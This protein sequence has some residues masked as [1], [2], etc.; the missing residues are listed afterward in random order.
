MSEDSKREDRSH[1]AS[2]LAEVRN[3]VVYV[4]AIDIHALTE[5]Q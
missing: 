1:A 3:D 4:H 5:W 2:F